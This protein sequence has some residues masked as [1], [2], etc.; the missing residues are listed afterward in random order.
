MRGG[1]KILLDQL[2]N[3]VMTSTPSAVSQDI[4]LGM[5]WSGAMWRTNSAPIWLSALRN[6]VVVITQDVGCRV[7]QQG[8]QLR[9]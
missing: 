3:K 7:V 1:R 5:L 4:V 6:S 9:S 8:R 2:I